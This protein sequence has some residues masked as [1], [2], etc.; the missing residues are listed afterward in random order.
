MDK[1]T[2]NSIINLVN[3]LE[4]SLMRK[5]FLKL[6]EDENSTNEQLVQDCEN[7]NKYL[8]MYCLVFKDTHK[9]IPVH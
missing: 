8:D 5:T 9:N 6:Q 1:Q 2:A 7:F 3:G 4:C